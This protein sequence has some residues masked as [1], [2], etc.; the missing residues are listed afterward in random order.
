[1]MSGVKTPQIEK[2]C[3][4]PGNCTHP[5]VITYGATT[6][7]CNLTKHGHR[8]ISIHHLFWSVP[9][10]RCS[11]ECLSCCARFTGQIKQRSSFHEKKLDLY[12][13]LGYRP[14]FL[15][16]RQFGTRS[17]E[18]LHYLPPIDPWKWHSQLEWAVL[19]L[20]VVSSA[21][22]SALVPMHASSTS[23]VSNLPVQDVHSK[24]SRE[25]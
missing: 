13:T 17:A 7:E 8:M 15:V 1:M 25:R 10:Y 14:P 11:F 5:Y 24:D 4:P 22:G 23:R 16:G 3:F 2:E 12:F 19:A 20:Q 9:R 18:Y 21:I 6:A